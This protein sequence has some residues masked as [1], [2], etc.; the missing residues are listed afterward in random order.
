[1]QQEPQVRP[2]QVEPQVFK[3][4]PDYPVQVGLPVLPAHREVVVHPVLLAQVVCPE[5]VVNRVQRDH[6]VHPV[7]A[8]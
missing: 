5:Q 7:Q 2:E 6:R 1:M 3:D 8:V 4:P